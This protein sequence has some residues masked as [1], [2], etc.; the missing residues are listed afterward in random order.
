VFPLLRALNVVMPSPH[1]QI[2]AERVA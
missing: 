2:C 1:R